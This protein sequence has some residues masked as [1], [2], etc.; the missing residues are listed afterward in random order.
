MINNPEK[1]RSINL[2]SNERQVT[3]V[4]CEDLDIELIKKQ[5][6]SKKLKEELISR[7]IKNQTKNREN[8]IFYTDGSLKKTSKDQVEEDDM[9]A[10]WLQLDE[11]ENEVVDRGAIGI[12]NWPSS[13]KAE[14]WAIWYVLLITPK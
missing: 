2:S 3:E 7:M 5:Q 14:L 4:V 8:L 11:N 1:S 6:V 13:M 12:R 9:G 10:G